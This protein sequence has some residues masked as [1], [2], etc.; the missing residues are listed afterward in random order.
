LPLTGTK[1]KAEHRHRI[2]APHEWQEIPH[3]PFK[4]GLKLPPLQWNGLPWSRRTR[5]WW[6][7]I[8]RMPHCILWDEADWGFALDTAYVHAAFCIDVR[9]ANELR[10]REKIMGTTMDARRDLR[11]RYIEPMPE[12][13]RKGVTAIQEYRARLGQ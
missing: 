9:H 5:D 4:R 11:I 2:K 1:P 8:S 7:V 13:E 12:E 10:Q 3:I 6:R